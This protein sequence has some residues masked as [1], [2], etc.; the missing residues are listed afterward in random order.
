M[1][2][3]PSEQPLP[4]A[5]L[6]EADLLAIEARESAADVPALVAAVRQLRKAV[7]QARLEGARELARRV[8]AGLAM[9]SEGG[10][11]AAGA[12][13]ASL[14]EMEADALGQNA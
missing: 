9:G 14:R 7:N 6:T 12:L 3:I 8:E 4:Q 13:A 1:T 11:G 5:H 2:D 10:S